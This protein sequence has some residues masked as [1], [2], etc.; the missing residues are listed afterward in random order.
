MKKLYKKI[1]LSTLMFSCLILNC[2]SCSSN[3]NSS[4][5]ISENGIQGPQGE[6]GEKGDKGDQGEP[7][8]DGLSLLTGEGIPENNLGKIGDSY[9]DFTTWDFYVKSED[10]WLKKG[11]ISFSSDSSSDSNNETNNELN[12]HQDWDKNDGS[13]LSIKGIV[14]DVI[15]TGDTVGSFY[16]MDQE[17]N[18]YYVYKPNSSG[19]MIG[20]EV[21]VSG[22]RSDDSGQER[23]AEGATYTLVDENK[24]SQ[25]IFNDV[26]NSFSSASN[27]AIY[28]SLG[29]QYQNLPAVLTKCKPTRIDGDNYY[30]KVGDSAVEFLILSNEYFLTD[31]QNEAWQKAFEDA[32]GTEYTF[33]IE[34]ILTV[35]NSAYTLQPIS[36]K[37]HVVTSEVSSVTIRKHDSVSNKLLKGIASTYN[38]EVDIDFNIPSYAHVTYEVISPLYDATVS[39]ENDKIKVI[40][41]HIETKNI[42]EA[43]VVIDGL[44]RK[45][46]LTINTEAVSY[47]GYKGTASVSDLVSESKTTKTE[48]IPTYTYNASE[49]IN[50]TF[51]VNNLYKKN[52][53]ICFDKNVND[54]TLTITAPKGYSISNIEVLQ[55]GQSKLFK[56][57]E[58]INS[59]QKE[60]SYSLTDSLIKINPNCSSLIID[61]PTSSNAVLYDIKLTLVE[62]TYTN[63]EKIAREYIASNSS[64]YA[65]FYVADNNFIWTTTASAPA[66]G[67]EKYVISY[68][69]K[70]DT[71]SL[72][73]KSSTGNELEATFS[74]T[75]NWEYNSEEDNEGY[76]PSTFKYVEFIKGSENQLDRNSEEFDSGFYYG[77]LLAVSY[78]ME[79]SV[80]VM[81]QN[82]Y[83][84]ALGNS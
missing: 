44:I 8:K 3:K 42:V 63:Y 66:Y 61:N 74:Y 13:R 51:D 19:V 50:V 38:Q 84:L 2:V 20:D 6:K 39:I 75:Y 11:N 5:Q 56:F 26:S 58:V 7:G 53:G 33:T 14:V 64:N 45:T 77:E 65:Q 48:L 52:G 73:I 35:S 34:G 82:A 76:G 78:K 15:K 83:N 4:S 71:G 28:G 41:S 54:D 49:Q 22:T 12:N 72:Y 32:I 37:S 69:F 81:V 18:G 36:L 79:G 29:N 59:Q 62:E 23:F 24:E 60:I 9:I 27:N 1:I 67:C 31:E 70:T 47:K 55:E 10:G 68:D 57:Y 16:M 40:P 21:I 17:G 80:I 25:I 30:F 46:E 43:T